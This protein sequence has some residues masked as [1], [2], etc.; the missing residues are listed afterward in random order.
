MKLVHKH[1]SVRV[2]LS[3]ETK[4]NTYRVLGWKYGQLVKERYNIRSRNQADIVF[5]RTVSEL[6][7]K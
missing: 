4:F 6:E 3:L 1:N 7:N 2:E 5:Q